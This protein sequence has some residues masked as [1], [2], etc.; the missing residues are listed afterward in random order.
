MNPIDAQT[1]LLRFSRRTAERM[2]RVGRCMCVCERSAHFV[3]VYIYFRKIAFQC[4]AHT[5][6]TYKWCWQAAKNK[7]VKF[8]VVFFLTRFQLRWQ[9]KK[10]IIKFGI[11]RERERG[12]EVELIQVNGLD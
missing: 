1:L 9:I 8:Y 6:H 4:K 2:V 12:R 11:E 5:A 7:W 10:N 3:I